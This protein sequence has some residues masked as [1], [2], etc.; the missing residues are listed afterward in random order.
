MSRGSRHNP[1]VQFFLFRNQVRWPICDVLDTKLWNYL[2]PR[3]PNHVSKNH[4]TSLVC[5][6]AFLKN[7][8]RQTLL[9][10]GGTKET[11]NTDKVVRDC[12]EIQV[13]LNSW[14]D[15]EMFWGSCNYVVHAKWYEIGQMSHSGHDCFELSP[16]SC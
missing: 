6:L 14:I 10:Q 11:H 12:L 15:F 7:R 8:V 5:D 16:Y 13:N 9:I 3:V 2:G 1:T 4:R